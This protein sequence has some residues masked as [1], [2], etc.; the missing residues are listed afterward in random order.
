MAVTEIQTPND[1]KAA[2]AAHNRRFFIAD[3]TFFSLGSSFID[4]NSVLPTYVSTLTA[5]PLLIGLVSTLRGF[6]YLVPQIS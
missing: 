3:G 5:S 4:G 6:G 2:V 1:E